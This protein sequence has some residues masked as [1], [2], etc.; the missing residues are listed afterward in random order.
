MQINKQEKNLKQENKPNFLKAQSAFHFNED[1]DLERDTSTAGCFLNGRYSKKSY[2]DQ[3]NYKIYKPE[4]TNNP[5]EI[6]DIGE[7]S[8]KIDRIEEI[9]DESVLS[10]SNIIERTVTKSNVSESQKLYTFN[11]DDVPSG[12]NFI[13]QPHLL[14]RNPSQPLSS[15]IRQSSFEG[16]NHLNEMNDLRSVL[17]FCLNSVS[18][19]RRILSLPD[20]LDQNLFIEAS[21]QSKHRISLLRQALGRPNLHTLTEACSSRTKTKKY[22]ESFR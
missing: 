17:H 9:S 2:H 18:S 19:T 12:V 21:A 13:F 22:E 15:K 20:K 4:K 1:G 5:E 14:N 16:L 10:Q 8:R 6:S 7:Y 3:T 11:E